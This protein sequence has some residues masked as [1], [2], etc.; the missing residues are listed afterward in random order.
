MDVSQSFV[1]APR[2]LTEGHRM[3]SRTWIW[4]SLVAIGLTGCQSTQSHISAFS[5]KSLIPGRNTV[6]VEP[7]SID[8]LASDEADIFSTAELRVAEEESSR[9]WTNWVKPIRT[10]PLPRTDLKSVAELL[11]FGE[12]EEEIP[13]V[14]EA[15][16][17]PDRS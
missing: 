15:I 7:V 9:S 1:Q 2:A 17:A 16:N 12:E 14:G 8:G 6:P 10:I 3:L 11:N 13:M 4:V 5:P